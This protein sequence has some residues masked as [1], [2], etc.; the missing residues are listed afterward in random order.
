MKQT[1]TAVLIF[2]T[3]SVYAQTL[4]TYGPK[5]VSK[6]EFLRAYNKNNTSTI[7]TEKAYR[8]Y[9]DLYI[10][11]KLKVQAAYDAKLDTISA[12][13]AEL[14]NFRSQ[15][16]ESFMNDETS[17]QLL[18]NEAF[19]RSQ[20]DLRISHIYLPFDNGDT[21]AAFQKAQE[22]WRKINGGASF[23]SVAEAYSADPSVHINKG[24]LGFI[25][26]F[27]LPYEFENIVY[28]TPVGKTASPYRS[29]TG[30]HLFSTTAARP[31]EG[32][33]K[34]A[35]ILIG[36]MP[37]ADNEE[38]QR[39]KILADSIYTA[40]KNGA[41]FKDMV[42][43]YSTDNISFQSGGILPEF[44]TGRYNTEFEQAAFALAKDG[45]IAAPILTSF[46]FHII[47]RLERIPVNK[48]TANVAAMA[49]LKQAV[50][51]D[52][53][54][55]VARQMLAQKVMKM[56]GFAMTGFNEKSLQA[57]IDSIYAG[58]QPKQLPGMNNNTVLFSFPQQKFTADAFA[59]YLTG[60][61]STP[62]LL[63]GKSVRQLLNQYA[64]ATAL[65]YYRNHL[66]T[67]N[68]E[69]A[70]QLKEFKDGNLLFEIMQRRVWDKAAADTIA[71]KKY[72]AGNKTKYWWEP[73]A[74][75]ILF[76]CNDSASAVKARNS[77]AAAPTSWKTLVQA[78]DGT[79]Q[80]D[81]GRFELSQLPLSVSDGVRPGLVS[82]PV[83]SATDNTSSF[84]YVVDLYK[85]RAP[86]SFEDARGFVINDYQAF[87]ENQWIATLRTKYPVKVNEA[88]LQSCWK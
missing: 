36:F 20:Q 9:L 76:T 18:V 84:A 80:A 23:A 38:R 50:Q 68:K 13:A 5:Q 15:I 21:L 62:D 64:E 85:D 16:I 52:K 43:K 17:I 29:R 25:T 72:Y 79:L 47:E 4:F 73:S 14:Q 2:L 71:L 37:N 54:I 65:D 86:R 51:A 88:V 67:Y 74:N 32:R 75:V 63:R 87:L 31:A 41:S 26:V 55:L 24:D 77:I 7:N 42:T 10:R 28:A 58:K 70:S 39:K 27:T 8:E 59:K 69:F 56:T 82:A 78:S 3:C 60:L 61:K 34:A 46:G 81:S 53:R 33:M 57:Y 40:L 30:Y 11:F 83:K 66:E 22:A 45:D 19:K 12:Q 1:L 35:Q 48:D 44:G 49:A 6:E